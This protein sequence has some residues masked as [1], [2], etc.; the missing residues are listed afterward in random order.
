MILRPTL[1]TA[2]ALTG[3]LLV[4]SPPTLADDKLSVG[5]VEQIVRDYLM[6]E[7]EIIYQAI[8]E[9][10]KRQQAA[11]AT[12]QQEMI[13]EHSN[14]IFRKTKDPLAGNSSGDITLVEFF[15]YRCG[16]CRSMVSGLQQLIDSD[17]KLRFVFKELPVLGPDS[18]VAAQA[19]LAA[20]KLDQAKYYDFHVALMQSKDLD[21]G[22]ILAIAVKQ[23]YD[24]DQIAAEMDQDWVKT[25]IAEN[26]ALAEKLGI[27]GTPSFVIGK[28]LIPGAVDLTKLAQIISDERKVAN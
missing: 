19:A 15:D 27:S 2:L 6:R 23:G 3:A 8:Q 12:R 14:D 13:A 4:S 17:Q 11:E 1:A 5:G 26:Q 10:Q 20:A 18:V 21:R 9:L 24:R 22:T 16:Y 25:R 7:P 28:T